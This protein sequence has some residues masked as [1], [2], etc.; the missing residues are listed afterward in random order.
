MRQGPNSRRPRGGRPGGRRSYNSNSSH[1]RTLESNGPNVKLRGTINQLCEKYQTLA[2]DAVSAGNRVSAE[3]YFQ[4]AEHYL[5]LINGTPRPDGQPSAQTNAEP[6]ETQAAEPKA[7]E[8]GAEAEPS[9]AAPAPVQPEPERE[10]SR[11]AP[12]AGDSKPPAN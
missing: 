12:E 2:R 11:A 9:S 6:Q 4:H 5:R 10:P 3:N 8:A 1:S 7:A